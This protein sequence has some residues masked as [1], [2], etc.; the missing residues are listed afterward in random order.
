M[1]TEQDPEKLKFDA[2]P[3]VLKEWLFFN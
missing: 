3:V 1:S 2:R